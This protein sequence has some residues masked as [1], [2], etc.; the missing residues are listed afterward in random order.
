MSDK[1]VD[2]DDMVLVLEG[3]LIRHCIAALEGKQIRAYVNGVFSLDDLEAQ[4]ESDNASQGL[5]GVG[6][7]YAGS[8]TQEVDKVGNATGDGGKSIMTEMMFLILIMAPTDIIQTQREASIEL[9]T[10]LKKGILGK[11]VE[12]GS[13]A[14]IARR[15]ADPSGQRPW[16][17][18]QEKPEIAE[19]TPTMLYYTQVWRLLM[20]V[21][22]N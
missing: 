19:S 12:M 22:G 20:P 11:R 13:A 9:L 4:M 5:I 14:F 7:S 8:K 18:V 15:G 17:F 2:R 3:D 6:V 1:L 10:V 21:T 16:L